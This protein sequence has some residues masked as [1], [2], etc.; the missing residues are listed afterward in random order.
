MTSFDSELRLPRVENTCVEV[1]KHSNRLPKTLIPGA[2]R[3]PLTPRNSASIGPQS[4]Y[5]QSTHLGQ[6]LFVQGAKTFER[7][8][9]TPVPS[10]P[11]SSVSNRPS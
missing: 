4:T 9:L 8:S 6:Q 3:P 5:I 10:L 7:R 11:P 2:A 1:E